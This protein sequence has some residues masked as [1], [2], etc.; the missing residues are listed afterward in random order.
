MQR[1]DH[2]PFY[3]ATWVTKFRRPLLDDDLRPRLHQYL[4]DKVIEY[5]GA[6]MAV[7]GT[8]DHVH[9]VF[10]IPPRA[11]LA[12]FIGRLKGSSSHWVNHFYN[13]GGDFAWQRGYGVFPVAEE[14]LA[15]LCDYVR[16]QIDHHRLGTTVPAYEDLTKRLDSGPRAPDRRAASRTSV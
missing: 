3:H 5:G 8:E 16:N 10:A 2:R 12:P 15:S 4:H 13:P 6:I 9:L 11:E 14:E 7:G 1:Q